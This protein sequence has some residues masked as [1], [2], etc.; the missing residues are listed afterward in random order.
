VLGF[1]PA[2]SFRAGIADTFGWYCNAGY[3]DRPREPDVLEHTHDAII[4]W[5]MGGAG[6]QYW[7]RAA[8]QLYGFTRQQALGR[9]TH[10]LLNT[11]LAGG[12]G[13]LEEK[14]SRYGVWIGHLRH[15]R[16]DGSSVLVD[17]RLSLMAQR[18]GRWLVLEVNR[19]VA[20]ISE[21]QNLAAEMGAH[22][23][24]IR[25]ARGSA[26]GSSAG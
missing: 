7:N 25:Q 10:L 24:H 9:T 19:E 23:A 17:A 14:L 4:V 21:R 26:I 13:E 11:Q 3:L 2:I 8:E 18:D 16:L 6:I 5:E 15:H 12:T 20:T 22:L 1:E